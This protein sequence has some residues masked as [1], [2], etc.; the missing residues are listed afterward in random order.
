[1]FQQLNLL[2]YN[3]HNNLPRGNIKNTFKKLSLVHSYRT[4]SVT[5]EN[6]FVEETRTGNMKRDF[7]IS[8]ALNRNVQ[9]STICQHIQY[10]SIKSERKNKL[11]EVLKKVDNHIFSYFARLE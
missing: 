2:L 4:I 3:V 9:H 10:K 5:N 7:S 8:C 6:Y 1:M 11:F